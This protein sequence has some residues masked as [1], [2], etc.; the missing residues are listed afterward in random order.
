MV[1]VENI[2]DEARQIVGNSNDQVVFKR[3]TDAVELLANKGDWDP[4]MGTLDIC[5][6]G[7]TIALPRE[8]ETVLAVNMVGQPAIPRDQLFSFHINGPGECGPELAWQWMD[9]GEACVYREIECPSKLIGFCAEAEDANCELWVEGEDVNGNLVR[10]KVGNTW[11]NG[12]KVPVFPNYQALPADAPVFSRITRV[13]KPV[14]AGPVRLSTVDNDENFGLLLGIF[15]SDETAP[16]YRRIRISQSVAFVR[17]FFRR[18]EFVVRSKKDL[19]PLHNS[20]AVLMMLRA[21][22]AYATPGEFPNGEAFESTAMR[23]LS[24]EQYTRT[25]PVIHPIQVHDATPLN[26][27]SDSIE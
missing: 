10:T 7:R 27:P 24:E 19:I 4:L 9:L 16:R 14:T 11:V 8:V 23:W 6:S 13:R 17:I 25:A 15:Q 5:V 3:I 12:W 22:K 20:Q 26:D 18:R 2:W 1:L 21:L